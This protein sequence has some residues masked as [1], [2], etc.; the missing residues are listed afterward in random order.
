MLAV[1]ALKLHATAAKTRTPKETR[2][3]PLAVRILTPFIF[4]TGLRVKFIV[5]PPLHVLRGGAAGHTI[6]SRLPAKQIF[7]AGGNILSPESRVK[8]SARGTG[9]PARVSMS[10]AGASR[11]RPSRSKRRT[12]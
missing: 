3:P 5:A 10:Q 6:I 11:R 4:K 12:R 1:E 9:R 8:E 7:F 2:S